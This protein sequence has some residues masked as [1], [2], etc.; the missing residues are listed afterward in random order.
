MQTPQNPMLNSSVRA[1]GYIFIWL[2]DLCDRQVQCSRKITVER[3][4]LCT[5]VVKLNEIWH[6]V[7]DVSKLMTQTQI[8]QPMGFL[9]INNLFPE[10]LFSKYPPVGVWC[11]HKWNVNNECFWI[12][13][14]TI[15]RI[16][17]EV[18]LGIQQ[19]WVQFI[20]VS[21]I[22]KRLRSPLWWSNWAPW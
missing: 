18:W 14:T 16:W 11:N 5:F 17:L 8:P 15:K 22:L 21:L 6:T 13:K 9:K 1:F 2:E 3:H 7:Y 12:E 10:F 4:F 19:I 20:N